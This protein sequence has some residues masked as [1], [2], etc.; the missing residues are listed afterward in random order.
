MHVGLLVQV[1]V[2]SPP[3]EIHTHFSDARRLAF[4]F[5]RLS[6]PHRTRIS[7]VVLTD[8]TT[9]VACP[10]LLARFLANC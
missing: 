3:A 1:P 9:F 4:V 6:P 10:T 2:R 7:S 5:I 8:T